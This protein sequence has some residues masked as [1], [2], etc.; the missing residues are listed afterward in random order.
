MLRAAI[1]FF[2][3]A[4]V[5]LALNLTGIAGLSIEIARV[6]IGVFL[7]LAIVSAV[8]YLVTGKRANLLP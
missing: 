5:A 6:L 7:V 3:L 2:V 1:G 4:V 8:V